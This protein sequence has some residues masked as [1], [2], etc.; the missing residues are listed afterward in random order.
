MVN[1]HPNPTPLSTVSP[2]TAEPL[3]YSFL[4]LSVHKMGVSVCCGRLARYGCHTEA[5]PCRHSRS[6]VATDKQLWP[7]LLQCLLDELIIQLHRP[8]KPDL[9]AI[10]TLH[11]HSPN[12]HHR[13]YGDEPGGELINAPEPGKQVQLVAVNH[14]WYICLKSKH[15]ATKIGL[16]LLL[17]NKQVQG[18]TWVHSWGSAP[19]NTPCHDTLR[20]VLAAK[21]LY[22]IDA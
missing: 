10:V 9:G 15:A 14:W 20:R 22:F 16:Q 7:P 8:D 21:R 6:A 19:I 11:M 5:P 4:S 13:R 12:Q 1:A 17:A 3:R 18:C 2:P